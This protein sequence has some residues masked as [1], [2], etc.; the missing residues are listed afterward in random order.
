MG[1]APNVIITALFGLI[2]SAANARKS[3]SPSAQ[4]FLTTVTLGGRDLRAL[5]ALMIKPNNA[6]MMTFSADPNPGLSPDHFSGAAIVFVSTIN[7]PT[8]PTRTA[9]LQ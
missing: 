2:I 7:Y 8:Y 9:A 1:S 5:A 3:R 4:R 6:V